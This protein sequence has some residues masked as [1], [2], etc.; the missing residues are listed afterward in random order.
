MRTTLFSSDMNFLMYDRYFVNNTDG[1]SWLIVD[2][3]LF[4]YNNL[5]FLTQ[6]WC[7]SIRQT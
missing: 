2:M 5:T 6:K 1:F 3:H 4:R 7:L